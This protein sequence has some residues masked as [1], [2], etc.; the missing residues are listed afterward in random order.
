MADDQHKLTDA[1]IY[2]RL[3]VQYHP[4]L[5]S[6]QPQPVR[7]LAIEYFQALVALKEAGE[8]KVEPIRIT[9]LEVP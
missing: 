8:L 2:Q 5:Y 6:D 4:D 1:Q 9:T 7:D 3:R